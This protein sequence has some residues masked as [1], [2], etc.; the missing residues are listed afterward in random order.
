MGNLANL[1]AMTVTGTPGTGP[2]TLNAA[3]TING[4]TYLTFTQAGVLT[5]VPVSYGLADTGASEVGF[6]S[7]SGGVLTR[8]TVLSSTNSNAAI[9]ASSATIV[10]VSALAQDFA[11]D[12]RN[13]LYANG[14]LEIWQ[15]GAGG[16]ASFA[17]VAAT[18]AYTA[19]RW[20]FTNNATQASVVSQQAGLTTQSR[21]SARILRNSG[22]TGT[23]VMRFE[24]ALTT[25]EIFTLR[26]QYLTF[27]AFISAGANWSPSSGNLVVNAY[28]GTGTE[29]RRGAVAYTG[30][31]NPLTTTI[32]LT[33]GG[34]AAQTTFTGASAVA[35]NVTQGCLQFSWTPVGTA[36]A[37]DSF[38]LD[39]VQLEIGSVASN[40][41]RLTFPTAL[42]QCQ[43]H[44]SKTWN[45][46]TAPNTTAASPGAFSTTDSVLTGL[47]S[48]LWRFPVEMRTTPTLT[49]ANTTWSGAQFNSN[50]TVQ[51]GTSGATFVVTGNTGG[52]TYNSATA[53][54]GL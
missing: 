42:I 13:I 7:V 45:Y 28:F 21:F 3:A 11:P 16:A 27:Q 6:G 1:A 41:E 50:G 22:Q 8:T 33:P 5:G 12:F 44:F 38:Q 31:T 32:A 37:A 51:V 26:G 48:A 40:F 34:A 18:P 39:D 43:R 35:T 53:D 4:V 47:I 52:P 19:D 29:G 24:Y 10:R 14:G 23:G 49:I 30:E 17:V 25:D 15:R 36:G 20:Y 9:N 46:A 2:I 54:A